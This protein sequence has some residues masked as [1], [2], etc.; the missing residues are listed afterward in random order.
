MTRSCRSAR[1]T[2]WSGSHGLA[3][4]YSE[5]RTVGSGRLEAGGE[6]HADRSRGVPFVLAAEMDVRVG[7]AEHDR[8]RLGTGGS[9]ED[10]LGVKLIGDRDRLEVACA[11]G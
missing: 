4:L 11:S 1:H 6:R 8:H 7:I 10:E 5:L 2:T 3:R 9:H